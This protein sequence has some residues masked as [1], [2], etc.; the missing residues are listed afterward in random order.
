MG[1]LCLVTSSARGTEGFLPACQ[2][3]KAEESVVFVHVRLEL[4]YEKPKV[5]NEKNLLGG[6]CDLSV[7][8]CTA[9]VSPKIFIS[10]LGST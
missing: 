3:R 4:T 9:A 7:G 5:K 10:A 6:Q 1:V 2:L 8:Q